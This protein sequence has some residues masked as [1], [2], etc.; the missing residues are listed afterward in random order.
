MRGTRATTSSDIAGS[1][2][3]QANI[4]TRTSRPWVSPLHARICRCRRA[5]GEH[6]TTARTLPWTQPMVALVAASHALPDGHRPFGGRRRALA[7]SSLLLQQ[8]R[9]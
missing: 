3:T 5:S 2:L 7:E 8:R 1:T 6:D 4:A 9:Y